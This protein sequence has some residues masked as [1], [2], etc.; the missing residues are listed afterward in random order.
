METEFKVKKRKEKKAVIMRGNREG[1]GN[2]RMANGEFR[3][4]SVMVH[5]HISA[6]SPSIMQGSSHD[7]LVD[8]F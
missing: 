8:K 6:F 4:V 5:K 3:S 1:K 7:S 2:I